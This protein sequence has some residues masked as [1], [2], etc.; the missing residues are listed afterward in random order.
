MRRT[1][2]E[3]TDIVRGPRE[4]H[5]S[6]PAASAIEHTRTGARPDRD[7]VIL[8]VRRK[9]TIRI[10]D[11]ARRE[12]ALFS[13][14]GERQ[15]LLR[16]DRRV[17]LFRSGDRLLPQR[18]HHIGALWHLFAGSQLWLT[19]DDGPTP[20]T[21]IRIQDILTEEGI[22]GVFFV[23]GAYAQKWPHL[24]KR[25]MDAGHLVGNHTWSH[26]RLTQL[27]KPNI[28]LELLKTQQAVFDATGQECRLFRP[29]WGALNQDAVEVAMQLGLTTVFWTVSAG[30]WLCPGVETIVER[31]T[32]R[33]KRGAVILLHDGCG[34]ELQSERAFEMSSSRKQ[35]ADALRETIHRVRGLGLTFSP[36]AR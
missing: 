11:R 12:G 5:H 23:C 31:I 19:F 8:I 15:A 20:H 14:H 3:L 4:I 24:V 21:S 25:A 6:R 32:R 34:D 22:R 10:P 33:A 9:A 26:P 13:L 7:V 28:Y 16:V 18:P 1:A 2:T 29:P 36:L 17:T 30:D 35:T 27:S